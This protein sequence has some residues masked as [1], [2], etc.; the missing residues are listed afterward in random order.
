MKHIN[1][2]VHRSRRSKGEKTI[3]IIGAQNFPNLLINSLQS[4]EDQNTSHGTKR[5][6]HLGTSYSN[7]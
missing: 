4:Q 7:C 2:Y 5:D 3:I 1:I 6:L